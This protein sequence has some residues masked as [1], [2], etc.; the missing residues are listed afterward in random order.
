MSQITAFMTLVT[1]HE[2]G[3]QLAQRVQQLRLQQGWT[4]ATL[5]ARAG[6]TVASLKRFETTGKASLDLV[7]R[8]VQALGRTGEFGPLL[9][10]PTA[11]SLAELEQQATRAER[12]RGRL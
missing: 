5:A 9:R 10:L 1:P 7:L 4:R 12:K 2:M 3:I 8:V 11:R 6:V